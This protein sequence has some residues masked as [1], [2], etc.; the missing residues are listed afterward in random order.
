MKA[1]LVKP[2]GKSLAEV[3]IDRLIFKSRSEVLKAFDGMSST[4]YF[5][6]LRDTRAKQKT[7]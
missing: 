5:R 3:L 2:V 1:V 7:F 4:E 6:H